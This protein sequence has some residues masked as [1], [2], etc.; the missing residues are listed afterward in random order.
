M[1][2]LKL[3]RSNKARIRCCGQKMIGK[4]GSEV[5]VYWLVCMF[6]GKERFDEPASR[7]ARKQFDIYRQKTKDKP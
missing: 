4:H 5:N 1:G 3:K 2:T 6:C 7:E